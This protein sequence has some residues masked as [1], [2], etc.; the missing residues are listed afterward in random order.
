[1]GSMLLKVGILRPHCRHT[2]GTAKAL[3]HDNESGAYSS[4]GMILAVISSILIPIMIIYSTKGNI[5]IVRLKKGAIVIM[6]KIKANEALVK[7]L[8]AWDIDHLYGIP[9]IQLTQ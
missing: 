4:I 8:E 5:Y 7:A 2:L 9:G 6:A 1:M 3:E